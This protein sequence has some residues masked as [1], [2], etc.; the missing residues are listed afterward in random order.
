MHALLL[1]TALRG[2]AFGIPEFH[3][4]SGTQQVHLLELFTSESCAECPAAEAELATV[5]NDPAIWK[6]FVPVTWHVKELGKASHDPF[7]RELFTQ[8]QLTYVDIWH[9][10]SVYTPVFVLD[11][12]PTSKKEWLP[13]VQM[14]GPE[15]VGTLT[16]DNT[17]DG[18]VHVTFKSVGHNARG[19]KAWVALVGRETESQVKSDDNS[20]KTQRHYF[21]VLDLNVSTMRRIEGAFAVDL[22]I[23]QASA[24]ASGHSIAIWVSPGGDAQ[25]PVQATGGPLD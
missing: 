22:P 21:V 10:P 15:T 6:H 19:W 5:R 3:F 18:R 9:V 17:A 1:V 13:S 14:L 8:R 23:G 24:P 7:A 11:G 20:G 16:A 4:E 12:S 2:A 25:V